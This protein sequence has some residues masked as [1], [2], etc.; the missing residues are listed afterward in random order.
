MEGINNTP[1]QSP[2]AEVSGD[3]FEVL[4]SSTPPPL[5]APTSP[6]TT[7]PR[8][9]ILR[10]SQNYQPNSDEPPRAF[11]DPNTWFNEYSF[12]LESNQEYIILIQYKYFLL[13]HFVF[14]DQSNMTMSI[15]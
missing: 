11:F 12:T 3:E 9:L 8:Q 13:G 14:Q 4:S 10:Y 6:S 1:P 7:T 2:P 5:T 15:Q